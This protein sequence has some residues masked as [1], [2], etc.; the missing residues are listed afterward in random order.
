MRRT[1]VA[2]VAVTILAAPAPARG[3][4]P[5]STAAGTQ[6]QVALAPGDS[7]VVIV[8][9]D[10][11]YDPVNP[12]D[13]FA[14]RRNYYM[15]PIWSSL[16]DGVDVCAATGSQ[17]EP[18]VAVGPDGTTWIAWHDYRAPCTQYGQVW[19]QAIAPDGSQYCPQDGSVVASFTCSST[20]LGMRNPAILSTGPG[21]GIV[22]WHRKRTT[23]VGGQTYDELRAQKLS[24]SGCAV[25]WGT[26]GVLVQDHGFVS[27]TGANVIIPY[28]VPDGSGGIIAVWYYRSRLYSRRVDSAGN[29]LWGTTPVRVCTT[30]LLQQNPA[31]ATDGSGGVIVTW[32][33]GNPGA[34][35]LLTQRIDN[36]GVRQWGD[37]G[38]LVAG[39]GGD[40]TN[41]QVVRS[42]LGRSFVVWQANYAPPNSDIF[43]QRINFLGDTLAA[44]IPVCTAPYGQTVPRA[45]ARSD[46][47]C[48]VV[49]QDGRDL[50]I[51]D[52]ADIFGQRFDAS[53]VPMCQ[54]DGVRLA[55]FPD[56]AEETIRQYDPRVVSV[57]IGG[58][59]TIPGAHALVVWNDTRNG[60]PDIY[61]APF[62]DD[63]QPYIVSV[64]PSTTDGMSGL[65]AT[66]PNPFSR[67]STIQFRLSQHAAVTLRVFDISG[68][69]IRVLAESAPMTAGQHEIDWDG[70][71]DTGAKATPGVYFY[72]LA[73]G[74]RAQ[75]YRMV[76]LK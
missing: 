51:G 21:T 53:G 31:L 39:S 63:C 46:G 61:A 10:N 7:S 26:G 67:V 13:I 22:L 30:E 16:T 41:P 44:R 69:L 50:A 75:S 6:D 45:A 17:T 74:S 49:W 73:T 12:Y 56:N 34:R 38:K 64:A 18:S 23:G 11:R 4:Y 15:N 54:P 58:S 9:R 62:A 59:T 25:Q 47:S 48:Y 33:Q 19:I 66:F 37:A 68:R 71:T 8:W 40:L 5:I 24:A 65:V 27:G 14:S 52:D 32:E 60:F 36:S 1:F 57:E 35:T 29:V 20:E 28:A 43:A 72:R 3:E 42:T 76:F 70:S 55:P 2:F